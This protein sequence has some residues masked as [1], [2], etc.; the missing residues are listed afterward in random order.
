MSYGAMWFSL[1]LMPW[2]AGVAVG[3]EQQTALPWLDYDAAV[4]ASHESSK[5]L[6]VIQGP[7]DVSIPLSDCATAKAIQQTVF[8]DQRLKDFY[9]FRVVATYRATGPPVLRAVD[10]KGRP[11]QTKS[12]SHANVITYF[13]AATNAQNVRVLHFVV[14][15]PT[16]LWLQAQC[17]WAYTAF[18][19]IQGKTEDQ[20]QTLLVD[21]HRQRLLAM[22]ESV[23]NPPRRTTLPEA[24]NL[25]S[26]FRDRRLVSRYGANWTPRERQRLIGSLR[27]HAELQPLMSHQVGV[28]HPFVKLSELESFAFPILTKQSFWA[29]PQRRSNIAKWFAAQRSQGRPLLIILAPTDAATSAEPGTGLW[30]PRRKSVRQ[31]L[32]RFDQLELNRTELICLLRDSELEVPSGSTFRSAR[33]L[34]MKRSGTD[35]SWLTD[36]D[37]LKLF[38]LMERTADD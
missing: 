13:C 9:Q 4:K 14:G 3:A 11:D 25:A 30:Q 21:L 29:P 2:W 6:L 1:L 38:R 18:E 17:D 34:I 12:P 28:L 5:L 26:Q 32:R 35:V 23:P 24:L 27:P 8:S 22:G 37:E 31:L 10:R 7:D 20:T 19:S 33:F 36:D 15:Y 16:P